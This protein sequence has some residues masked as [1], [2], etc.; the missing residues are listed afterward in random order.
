M[1]SFSEIRVQHQEIAL[2]ECQE[3]NLLAYQKVN[4][5]AYQEIGYPMEIEIG[6]QKS[7]F[8]GC[9]TEWI[10]DPLLNQEL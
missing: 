3:V 4:L 5:L 7:L 10:A 6:S 2:F 9:S 8:A 1:A